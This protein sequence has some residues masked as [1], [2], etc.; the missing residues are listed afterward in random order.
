MFSSLISV[1]SLAKVKNSL[2]FNLTA[3]DTLPSPKMILV[4]LKVIKYSPKSL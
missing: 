1:R 2:S 3:I 4:K